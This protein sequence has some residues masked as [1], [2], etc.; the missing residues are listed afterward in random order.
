LIDAANERV[1]VEESAGTR[2]IS[3][4]RF[5]SV[6]MTGTVE[7]ANASLVLSVACGEC[8]WPPPSSSSAPPSPMPRNAAFDKWYQNEH[9]PDAVRSFGATKAWR[10]WSLADPAVHLA[11]YE[12][13]DEAALERAVQG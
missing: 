5:E 4:H 6:W 11:M 10:F 3:Y 12:F 8:S 1:E 7:S 2:I 9:L 13:A